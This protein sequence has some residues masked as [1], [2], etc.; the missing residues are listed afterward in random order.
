MVTILASTLFTI[1]SGAE[2]TAE[3]MKNF[4]LIGTWST[5][6]AKDPAKD[7]ER[8][9]WDVPIF[10][11]ATETFANPSFVFTHE[12]K[13]AVRVTDEKLKYVEVLVKILEKEKPRDLLPGQ[14]MPVELVIIKLGNK[15][16]EIDNH[17]VDGSIIWVKDGFRVYQNPQSKQWEPG[18][19]TKAIEKCLQ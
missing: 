17:R 3:A 4:G 7:G 11:V 18:E 16:R 8:T 10:G 6:C 15:F 5:D 2:S 19:E 1:P 14:T 12:I 9:T 13:S